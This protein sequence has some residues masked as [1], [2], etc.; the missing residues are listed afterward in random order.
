MDQ[1]PTLQSLL[2][3]II[4]EVTSPN[5]AD[6]LQPH[7]M[8]GILSLT[9]LLGIVNL[10]NQHTPPGDHPQ[11]TGHPGMDGD[12]LKNIIG[13]LSGNKS[14]NLPDINP[15]TLMTIMGIL[16][17]LGKGKDDNNDNEN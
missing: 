17:S 11:L 5:K 4:Y 12:A 9:N 16:S 14:G 3:N 2:L 13:M 8:I 10:M 15:Q 1:S 7:Q 6:K